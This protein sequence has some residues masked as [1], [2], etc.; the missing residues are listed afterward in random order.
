MRKEIN[1]KLAYYKKGELLHKIIPIKWVSNRV[2]DWYG[3][4]QDRSN[5][6]IELT[7]A[8]KIATENVA[9][10]ILNRKKGIFDRR[11]DAKPFVEELKQIKKDLKETDSKDYVQA[12]FKLIERI[13]EDQGVDDTE[14]LDIDFWQDHVEP[15]ELWAFLIAVITKD[16][17]G[18]KKAIA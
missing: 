14:L 5:K 17:N 7:E 12:R 16:S 4:I 18:K 1:Y 8:Q 9:Y 2:Y 3:D 6:I 11:K 13:I 10:Q 15:S